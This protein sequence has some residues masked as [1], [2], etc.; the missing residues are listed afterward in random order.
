LPGRLHQRDGDWRE[1]KVTSKNGSERIRFFDA[2]KAGFRFCK[3]LIRE[4]ERTKK[5]EKL[6][7]EMGFGKER[8]E[9]Q[10]GNGVFNRKQRHKKQRP[11]FQKPKR[12]SKVM[13]KK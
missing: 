3:G 1:V 10:K 13:R 4:T 7:P 8:K 6:N 9:D 12:G 5:K 2:K 11:P